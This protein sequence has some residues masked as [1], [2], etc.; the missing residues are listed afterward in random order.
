[1]TAWKSL[2]RW[3]AFRGF[4]DVKGGTLSVGEGAC[5]V[6]VTAPNRVAKGL[7]K[8]I[9][10]TVVPEVTFTLA[11]D[12]VKGKPAVLKVEDDGLYVELQAKGL[13]LLIK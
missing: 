2:C 5:T 12:T 6:T 8:L 1:M 9:G 11:S 10:W 3:L 7:Y 4:F 13:T